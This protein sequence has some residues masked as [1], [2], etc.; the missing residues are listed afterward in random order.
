MDESPQA[1]K[2]DLIEGKGRTRPHVVS[3]AL[4]LQSGGIFRLDNSRFRKMMRQGPFERCWVHVAPT[5]DG[6]VGLELA[7]VERPSFVFEPGVSKSLHLRDWM[8][9]L[10]FEDKNFLGFNQVREMGEGSI[11]EDIDSIALG[12]L[13]L[14][15]LIG[16]GSGNTVHKITHF[17]VHACLS[18]SGGSW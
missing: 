12:V 1:K 18:V 14:S 15:S 13:S 7:V 8:G 2:P 16:H 3:D 9:D 10:Y 4:G 11:V 17:H 6:K 5:K